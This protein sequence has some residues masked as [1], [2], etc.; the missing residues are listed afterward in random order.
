M[1]YFDFRAQ[2]TPRSGLDGFSRFSGAE[3]GSRVDS[4][5]F[6]GMC[7]IAAD[8]APPESRLASSL[9]GPRWVVSPRGGAAGDLSGGS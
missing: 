9:V 5:K 1:R 4:T 7:V 3:S 8:G 6:A 2:V